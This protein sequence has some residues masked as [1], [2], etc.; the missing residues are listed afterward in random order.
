MSSVS[1]FVVAYAI[2]AA[3]E[4]AA[5]GA[6]GWVLC[7]LVR[8][9]GAAAE[10]AV[11]VGTLFAAILT[12]AIPAGW[13]ALLPLAG[14]AGVGSAHFSIVSTA[15]SGAQDAEGALVLPPW[16]VDCLLVLFGASLLYFALRFAG[17]LWCTA[18]LLA[19]AG[20]VALT[21]EQE[22]VWRECRR[23]YALDRVRMVASPRVS[24][25][26]ALR[27]RAPVL[28]L[29]EGFAAQCAAEDWRA[30]LAHECAHIHRRDFEKNLV[31]EALSLVVAFHPATWALKAKIAQTREIVCDRMA[32][33]KLVETHRYE[34]SLLRLA[35]MVAV[36]A[37]SAQVQAIG[38]FDAN[39]LEDRIMRMKIERRRV[40][41]FVRYV[42]G[43]PAA[44]VLL[45]VVLGSAAMAVVIEP[46]SQEAA[47]TNSYGPVY[48]IGKDV[49][50]PVPLKTVQAEFPK[51]SHG[52]KEKM[53]GI[54]L[55]RM[56]VDEKGLPRDPR[57]VRSLQPDYDA[58]ALKAVKQYRFKPAMRKGK[59]VAVALSIEINFKL[60]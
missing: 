31:Y 17:S 26:V 47:A 55:V 32:T 12:P 42:V 27:G 40:S 21:R 59:P 45:F 38:I 2:N 33:E 6:A 41:A 23:A 10:H 22:E 7:R 9:L 20:P 34:R 60:Y 52:V 37:R 25:P 18:T 48:K 11:W 28:L 30:A 29:P 8:G 49:S 19:G 44:L 13:Y 3:W 4:M 36:T 57:V 1:S 16:A 53:E 14:N 15:L 35:T 5:I 56:V 43:V 24:G 54:I 50:A 46:A 39:I 51:S 58:E